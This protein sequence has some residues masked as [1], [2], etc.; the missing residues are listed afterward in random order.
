[1]RVVALIFVGLAVAGCG[2]HERAP[3]TARSTSAG[4][5]RLTGAHPCPGVPGFTCATLN[6][7]LDHAGE[8]AGT[9]PL[10]VAVQRT[11]A[12]P[13]GVLLFLAGGPGQPGVSLVPK[14]SSRLAA[15]LAG[16]KLVMFDQRGTGAAGA[17]DCPALQ[18]D[19]GAS[20]LT[21]VPAG[22]I[23][24]CAR[25]LGPN[26]RYFSTPETVADVDSLR[27]ALGVQQLAL[28]GVS[29]GTFTA[30]RYALAYPQ[31][32]SRLVLDSV[33]P[34][35]GV[36]PLYLASVQA[37]ARVLRSAC[38]AQ[39]CRSD[40]AADL[41]ALIR[42]GA[43]GPTLQDAIVAESIAVPSFPGVAQLLHAAREGRRAGLVAWLRAVR[44][45]EAAPAPEL[46]QALHEATLCLDLAPPWNPA[47]RGATRAAALAGA[48]SRLPARAFF[49]F[50][51]ATATG[52]GIA[53][54]CV[55]WPATTPPGIAAVDPTRPLPPVPVLLLAGGRDLSTPLAWARTEAAYAARGRLVVVPDAGH[56]VQLRPAN[57]GAREVLARFLT[58]P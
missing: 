18:A 54:D 23:D 35:T 28:D 10:S 44:R 40:P 22:V 58:D 3:V 37:T 7:P 13:R 1:V 50:T 2:G 32:V 53:R 25:R 33:V 56:S 15:A 14:I 41:S 46:S 45:G 36:D 51:R 20:D 39:S 55:A 4:A 52:N 19:A 9:L 31:H 21:V 6:V 43:D 42:S 5:S 29:Y 16:Y 17:L 57:V 38:A 49:P 30:E 47:S 48:A 8:V 26:R 27:A 34:Q 11:A 12:A 24:G